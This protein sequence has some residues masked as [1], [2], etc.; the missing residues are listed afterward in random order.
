MARESVS[1]EKICLD[2]QVRGGIA[3]TGNTDPL[4]GKD[5]VEFKLSA[6]FVGFLLI[7][8]ILY[9][10][11]SIR[12]WA[13]PRISRDTCYYFHWFTIQDLCQ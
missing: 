13:G 3:F 7:K 2:V 5:S 9:D 4:C 8:M 6:L 10:R 11:G 1:S 12:L